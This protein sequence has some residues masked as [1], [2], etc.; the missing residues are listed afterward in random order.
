MSRLSG[1]LLVLSLA[2]VSAGPTPARTI[3][4]PRQATVEIGDGEGDGIDGIHAGIEV[5]VLSSF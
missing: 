5:R 2:A 4:S 3:F 1:V